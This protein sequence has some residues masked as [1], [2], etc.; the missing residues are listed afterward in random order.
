[1]KIK[2]L[3]KINQFEQIHLSNSITLDGYAYKNYGSYKHTKFKSFNCEKRHTMKCRAQVTL[4][5]DG[6]KIQKFNHT[7]RKGDYE[8]IEEIREYEELS[9]SLNRIKRFSQ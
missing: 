6:R 5:S 1:M 3:L 7:C 9:D 4:Y 2:F 8:S